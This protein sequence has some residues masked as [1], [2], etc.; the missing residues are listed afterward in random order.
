MT[1]PLKLNLDYTQYLYLG[2]PESLPPPVLNGENGEGEKDGP[3]IST[4]PNVPCLVDERSQSNTKDDYEVGTVTSQH[5]FL[6]QPKRGIIIFP[7][8]DLVS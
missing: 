6:S 7:F 2:S 4:A 5:A 3:G 8:N 1:P